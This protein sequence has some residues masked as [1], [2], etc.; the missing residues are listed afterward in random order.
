LQ[1]GS[2][3]ALP[4]RD[5]RARWE[6]AV[7]PQAS[8]IVIHNLGDRPAEASLGSAAVAISANGAAEIAAEPGQLRSDA[9]LLVLQAPDGFDAASL[10][11]DKSISD[12]PRQAHGRILP[13][14]AG[15]AWTRGLT[16]DKRSVRHGATGAAGVK[17]DDPAARVEVAV[18]FLA[19]HTRV[20]IRQL[21]AMGNEVTS[22]LAFASRPV[23]WRAAL[24][25]VGGESRIELETLRGEAQGTA[26][27][28]SAT[29]NGKPSPIVPPFTESAGG[30]ALYDPDINWEKSPPLYYR[31][32]GAPASICGD[33]YVSRNGGS[34]VVTQ[35]W[36]C[37]DASGNATKGPW[38]YSSQSADETAYAYVIWS[39]GQSTNTDVHIWDVFGPSASVTSPGASPAPTS[40]YGTA[41]DPAWG[42]GFSS[43]W[44]SYCTTYFY[45][46]TTGW[47]WCPG[48]GYGSQFPCGATCTISGMPSH[49]VT[50]SVSS[51]ALPPG[52]THVSGQCYE[53]GVY[54]YEASWSRSEKSGRATKTFCVP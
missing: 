20:R 1:L 53:W 27:V 13:L 5:V 35:N 14:A 36:I 28:K 37:T 15:P 50:W 9:A 46:T 7:E 10:E 44:G 23:R 33:I 47:Y 42:A 6:E 19:P 34:Y 21:D 17:S 45:N 52:Y 41:T 12:G 49:S 25:T 24:E 48:S 4:D 30:L 40:F 16:A 54:V 11:V 43:G 22:L 31:V 26:T 8:K 3:S 29:A 18:A 32:T 38:Y 2:A 51:S 39:N